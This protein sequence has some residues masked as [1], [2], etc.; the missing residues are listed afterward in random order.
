MQRPGKQAKRSK[1]IAL[2]L[3]LLNKLDHFFDTYIY[4]ILKTTILNLIKAKL[5][6]KELIVK[7]F[8][9]TREPV[10]GHSHSHEYKSGT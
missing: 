1:H 2:E 3:S 4:A 8:I 10:K 6:D 5:K 9:L 7:V